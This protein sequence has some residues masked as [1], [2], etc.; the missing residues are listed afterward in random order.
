M[1]DTTGKRVLM[2]CEKCGKNEATMYYK[3]T[4]NGVT[5]EMHLCPEC[6][7]KENLISDLP[8]HDDEDHM[9]CPFCLNDMY[10]EDSPRFQK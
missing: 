9:L 7:Q 4:V 8:P 5:R 1:T 2:K 10:R 3:E 6:A